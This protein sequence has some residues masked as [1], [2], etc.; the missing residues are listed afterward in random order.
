MSPKI[1]YTFVGVIIALLI[2]GPIAW[3]RYLD[4]HLR[5]LRVVEDGVLYRSGQLSLTGLQQVIH[6]YGIKTV[7]TLRDTADQADVAEEQYCRK[8]GIRFVRIPPRTWSSADGSVP[9]EQ[10]V[11]AF[12]AIMDD[13]G[14]YPVLVHCFAGVH[15]TGSYCAVYRM[16]YQGWSNA[17]AVA[18][19]RAVGYENLDDEM[20]VLGFL[21]D[22][23]RGRLPRDTAGLPQATPSW[24]G[25]GCCG[26]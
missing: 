22:Y 19:V 8:E 25:G 1:R 7:I 5:N 11:K 18:E 12:L 17:Q 23:R 16:E 6:D 2:G 10:G 15:R 13:P 26:D 3:S 21:E 4:R 20:D 24:P 9:A 14:N